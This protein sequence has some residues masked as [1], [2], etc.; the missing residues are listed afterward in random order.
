MEQSELEIDA[1]KAAEDIEAFI[2]A[3]ARA[4]GFEHVI[5]GM[6][7]GLDSATVC[8]LCARAMGPERVTAVMMPYRSTSV[9]SL[10]DA[11]AAAGCA[12]VAMMTVEIT[13]QVDAYFAQFP[14]ADARRRGTKMAR[15]RM[16]ILYDLSAARE[17]LVVGT[18]NKTE[19]LL[20]YFTLWGDMAAG[21]WPLATLYKTQ[22]RQ[23]AAHLAVPESIRVKPPS[24]DL[25]E[26]Q[27]DEGEL[28]M[29]YDQVDRVLH[30]LVDLGESP[31]HLV[32]LGFA[33]DVVERVAALVER[34][35]YKR[36]LPLTIDVLAR[37]E[38]DFI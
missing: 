5:L 1:S 14:D 26:G 28:G 7:G 18:S 8:A 37:E 19:W 32:R 15:E 34:T 16:A 22:V 29:R 10:A 36:R 31:A 25:W 3:A 24:A 17:A 11:Q 9:E 30:H 33:E 21:I 6:S 12:G 20:G 13:A 38:E 35:K 2:A 23:L 4:A 27:T